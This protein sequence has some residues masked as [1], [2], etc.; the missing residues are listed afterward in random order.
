MSKTFMAIGAHIGDMELT[1]GCV[2]AHQAKKGD[3]I[4]TVALTAG[5]RGNPKGMTCAEYRKQKVSEAKAFAEMLNGEAIVLDHIDGQLPDDEAVRFEVAQLIRAYRPNVI[6]THWGKSLHKDH[7]VCSRIVVDAQ[8]YAGID[9]G[10]KL[11]GERYYAPVYFAENWEDS[12]DFIP[13]VFVDCSDGFDLWSQAI[14]KHWFIMNSTSFRYY[15]YYTHLV[16]VRGALS[17]Q[18]QLAQCFTV[19]EHQKFTRVSF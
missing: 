12:E 4:I 2:L 11:A 3:K 5:E 6:F 7:N 1:A 8:F 9:V 13:Y 17:R 15:D 16:H 18:Y 14:Q 19:F 10:D